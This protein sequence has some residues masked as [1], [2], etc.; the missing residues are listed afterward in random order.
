MLGSIAEAL[1]LAC[2]AA[3]SCATVVVAERRRAA[4]RR[5]ALDRCLHELRRPLQV[6]A[7][8]AERAPGRPR[9]QLAQA[10][11]A[12][13]GV[14]RELNG[15]GSPPGGRSVVDARSLAAETVGRW[16]GPAALEGR[17]IELRL[18]R[19]AGDRRRRRGGDLGRARQPDRQRARARARRDPPRGQRPRRATAPER[20][21]R[22]RRGL[23]AAAACCSS[24]G[25]APSPGG[26]SP[27]ATACG[28]SPRSRP[29][30]AVGSPPAPTSTGR[31]PCS[32]CRSPSCGCEPARARDRVRLGRCDLRRDS[33]SAAA[34]GRPDASAQ[35]GSLRQ[36][37]VA[38]AP[39]PASRRLGRETVADSLELRRV[40]AVVRPSGCPHESGAGARPPAG[41]HDPG[42]RVPARLAV[43]RRPAAGAAP[44]RARAGASA[45]GA[46]PSV[47]PTRS[48]ETGG[49]V[50]VVVT[51][52]GGPAG[53]A[54][55]TFVAAAGVRL[56]DLRPAAEGTVAGTGPSTG[57]AASI[58]TLALT[59]GAGAA[60][61]PRAELRA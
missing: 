46:R 52:A 42:R 38:A 47:A 13:D 20:R 11:A 17:S 35:Y 30:T 22:R 10:L 15:A 14:E 24:P 45:G 36:V 40:P 18:E 34:G 6:L 4:R 57:A 53:G 55:R 19:G 23:A 56:L 39:L 32:S 9:D 51:T 31:A 26:R 21:R 27:R 25:R 50:D 8:E 2:P 59:R 49:R 12:L 33:P 54:G 60:P 58:A 3:L 5:R 41:E 48:A 44:R 61:D 37:V 28:S 29:N 7:L 43:R 1:V 16:R